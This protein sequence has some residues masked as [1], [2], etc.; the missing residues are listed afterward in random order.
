MF[1]LTKC[2]GLPL[3]LAEAFRDSNRSELV[4]ILITCFGPPGQAGLPVSTTTMIEW[5]CEFGRLVPRSRSE[6]FSC[7]KPRGR[8]V[9]YI[10]GM[11][12]VDR[13]SSARDAFTTG[14]VTASK[15]VHDT[16]KVL[17]CPAVP[18]ITEMFAF[19]SFPKKDMVFLR[20]MPLKRSFRQALY[21][22]LQQLA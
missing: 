5:S 3:K 20:A 12:S 11:D 13:T 4:V 16:K 8:S 17:G 2:S 7:S 1:D 10:V 21:Q 18:H 19:R 6:G 9:H 14:D 22:Y 15:I